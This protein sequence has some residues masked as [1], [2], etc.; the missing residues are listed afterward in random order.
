MKK[1]PDSMENPIDVMI[2]DSTDPI[3]TELNKIPWMTPNAIT[4]FG[5][6]VGIASLLFYIK[7]DWKLSILFFMLYYYFDCMDGYYARKYNK[8]SVFGDYFDHAR[9][10]YISLTMLVLI[11]I[12]LSGGSDKMVFIIGTIIV[13]GL[14]IFY[15]GCQE[16]IGQKVG[17]L[18][19]GTSGTLNWAK[20]AC[21]DPENMI[22]ISRFCSP[23]IVVLFICFYIWYSNRV[24]NC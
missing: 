19:E 23:I 24:N 8:I 12:K 5:M 21:P 2:Y 14:C 4:A 16:S 3:N 15:V 6:V 20:C 17:M 1:V 7:G 13:V 18:N 9:D 22:K 10:L 11:F